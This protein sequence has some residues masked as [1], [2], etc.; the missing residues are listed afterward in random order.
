MDGWGRHMI[1]CQVSQGQLWLYLLV[2]LCKLTPVL[3]AVNGDN[4]RDD[5]SS[6]V[7]NSTH[8]ALN[9]SLFNLQ[10]LS[11]AIILPSLCM[12]RHRNIEV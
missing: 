4:D 10:T 6:R 8:S 12:K 1:L 3:V 11:S 7:C 5:N 2:G 9:D